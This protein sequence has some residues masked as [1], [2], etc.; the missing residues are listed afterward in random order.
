MN[1]EEL[2]QKAIK[3]IEH[4]PEN[5]PFVVKEL[6]GTEWICLEKRDKLEFGRLF[7]K[8][9][10]DGNIPNVKYMGKADNNSAKYIKTK[11]K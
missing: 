4:T 8:A 11:E 10:I 3:N 9:V 7:K 5:I 2:L 6:F 1:Y